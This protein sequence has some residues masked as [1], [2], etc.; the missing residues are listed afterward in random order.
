[1]ST[2]SERLHYIQKFILPS[3]CPSLE[4]NNIFNKA[5]TTSQVH[6]FLENSL[7]HTCIRTVRRDL[8]D[9]VISN[10]IFKCSIK[11]KS[12][13]YTPLK[14]NKNSV[15]GNLPIQRTLVA[16]NI[17]LPITN[18]TT[19]QKQIFPVALTD[20]EVESRFIE[21]HGY[22]S[23]LPN[24]RTK[25]KVSIIKSALKQQ[26]RMLFEY[27]KHADGEVSIKEIN[28]IGV[29]NDCGNYLVVGT[30]VGQGI[31]A[32]RRYKISKMRNI[33]VLSGVKFFPK[34]SQQQA[35]G[36]LH[37]GREDYIISTS[38]DNKVHLLVTKDA[39]DIFSA[40]LID[41]ATDWKFKWI[42]KKE[43]TAELTFSC[44]ISINFIKGLLSFGSAIQ[45]VGPSCLQK[46][47]AIQT[48][49]EPHLR[50]NAIHS[51]SSFS[52]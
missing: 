36:I 29:I 32:E 7:H 16:S 8:E 4:E 11:N 15:V 47:L 12:K 19:L 43:K 37:S 45:I 49:V 22:L 13:Y 39:A 14:P 41:G 24:Q 10:H 48:Q 38:T 34:I 20:S 44:A 28:P 1:M 26:S 51:L 27:D 30:K 18:N 6:S 5:F 35:T 40:G 3:I 50:K 46:A 21:K 17:N 42:D 33:S 25:E 23:L 9:L 52:C 31:E 2:K